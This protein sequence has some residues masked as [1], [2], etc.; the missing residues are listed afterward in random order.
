MALATSNV[1]SL[2]PSPQRAR[3][4]GASP[5]RHSDGHVVSAHFAF[6]DY[7]SFDSAEYERQLKEAF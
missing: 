3:H 4:G 2:P 7:A 5:C 6:R 1:E